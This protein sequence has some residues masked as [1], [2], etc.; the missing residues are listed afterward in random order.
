QHPVARGGVQVAGARVL[1]QVPDRAAAVD[2]PGVR[3]GLAG[4]HL[5]RGRLAGAVAADESDPVAGLYP[6]LG[7]GQQDARAGA[8]FETGGTDHENGSLS[9]SS[10]G[11]GQACAPAAGAVG[12]GLVSLRRAARVRVYRAL[13]RGPPQDYRARCRGTPAGMELN[14]GAN[15]DTSQ[16]EDVRGSTGGGG[17]GFGLP[18]PIGGGR[19]GLVSTVVILGIML[20]VGG[21]FGRNLIG[22]GSGAQPNN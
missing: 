6:Q 22:G 16:V 11:P 19:M 9:G 4:Q 20:C 7:A 18:I 15:L 1:R 21:V 12:A 5:Q 8:Q 17:G 14:E 3:Q 13:T 2:L 10:D